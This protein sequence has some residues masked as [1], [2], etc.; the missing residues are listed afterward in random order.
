MTY[1]S[2]AGEEVNM[3]S[4][5]KP[6]THP[7][8]NAQSDRSSLQFGI[9]HVSSEAY[10]RYFH[11]PRDLY[12]HSKYPLFL[13]LHGSV[14]PRM[15]FPIFCLGCWATFISYISKH[16]VSLSAEPLLLTVLGLVVGL[17]LSFRSSTAYERYSEGRKIWA[18]LLVHSRTLARIIWINVPEVPSSED[19]YESKNDLITKISAINL[20]LAFAISLKHRLRFQPYADYSDLAPLIGHLDTYAKNAHD[21]KSRD[22]ESSLRKTSVW[23]KIGE[24]LSLSFAVSNPRKAINRADAPLGN[25]PLEI[26]TYLSSYVQDIATKNRGP[27]VLNPALYAQLLIAL[28]GL[29]E[30]QAQADRILNTPLPLGYNILISQLV[31]LYTYLLPFQLLDK[32]G[33]ITIPA[34]VA[35]SYVI[36]GIAAIG[37]E[38]DNPFGN[39][40]NDLPLDTYCHELRQDLD[41]LVSKKPLDFRQVISGNLNMPLWPLSAQ[42]HDGILNLNEKNI[43]DILKAKVF[44][45]RNDT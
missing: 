4:A 14:M 40:V 34:T 20:I 13:R 2:I 18:S 42:G 10:A 43:R 45:K 41:C 27:P 6:M 38:L 32:L 30:V 11:G 17:C 12:R 39:D 15:I 23:K 31:I 25:L 9:P 8:S 21:S 22:G 29:T 44:I 28:A 26:I 33:W 3:E 5:N 35:A 1:F 7:Y 24:F 36:I 37:N 16:Y 19:D